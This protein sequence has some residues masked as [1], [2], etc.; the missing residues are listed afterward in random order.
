MPPNAY[1]VIL[2][3]NALKAAVSFLDFRMDGYPDLRGNPEE[4]RHFLTAHLR[5]AISTGKGGVESPW[6]THAR[7]ALELA[8]R[9]ERTMML[10]YEDIAKDL[11]AFAR[12]LAE[13]LELEVSE[14][15]LME[16]AHVCRREAMTADPRFRDVLLSRALG[17]TDGGAVKARSAESAA[18]GY[19]GMPIPEEIEEEYES[20]LKRS[21]GVTGYGELCERVRKLDEEKRR[22]R[23]NNL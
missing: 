22:K 12:R 15:A 10:C 4:Q 13:H 14:E 3:R 23:K 19:A 2:M 21:F 9:S 17:R 11:P 1:V 20:E 5:N 8:E 6:F 18:K 16:A 7:Q